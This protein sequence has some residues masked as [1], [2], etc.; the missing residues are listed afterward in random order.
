M[1]KT[2]Y[3]PDVEVFSTWLNKVFG[4]TGHKHRGTDEDGD[5][6]VIEY[7]QRTITANATLDAH[8]DHTVYID[9]TGG[10]VVVTLPPGAN[11]GVGR[12]Y[13]LIRKDGSANTVTI[14]RDGTD[15]IGPYV[16]VQL[17][18]PRDTA[19][20]EWQGV[21]LWREVGSQAAPGELKQIGTDK[22]PY[23]WMTCYGQS[24]LRADYPD[25]FAA[26]GTTYGSA[27]GTHF[28]LPDLRGRILMGM[29]NMGGT[30]ADRVTDAQADVLGGVMG[31]E[32]HTLTIGEMPNHAHTYYGP[33][34]ALV[35]GGPAPILSSE[36]G[37]NTSFVGGGQAHN[38]IQPTM[39]VKT[40]IKI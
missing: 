2:I 13:R 10:N 5:A 7:P 9:A 17:V 19:L 32:E 12:P 22:V 8:T 30:P 38:N 29:D 34:E 33:V 25:L 11:L 21:G 24:V 14:Q 28:S 27:D 40:I 1:A 36:P 16:S 6:P 18:L 39:A 23:G 4:H 31:E 26:I 3:A 35:T 15:L 37:A 20:L